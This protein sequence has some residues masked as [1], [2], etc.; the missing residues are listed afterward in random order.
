MGE[1]ELLTE[2]VARTQAS[3]ANLN[4]LI[5]FGSRAR[6]DARADSD[7]DLVAIVSGLSGK[8]PR[9]LQWRLALR[10]LG[11]PLDLLVLTESEW[12]ERLHLDGS[13]AHEAARDG[14]V[15]YGR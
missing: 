8:G 13:A 7:F 4:R 14:K 10:S 2:I 6:G 12:Q 11:V 5:L 3:V 15:L 9:T 1:Q